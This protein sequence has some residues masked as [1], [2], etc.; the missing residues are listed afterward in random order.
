MSRHDGAEQL[1]GVLG[2]DVVDPDAG[3]GTRCPPDT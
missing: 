2:G 1:G 3:A